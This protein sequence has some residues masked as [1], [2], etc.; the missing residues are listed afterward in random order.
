[1]DEGDRLIKKLVGLTDETM[2]SLD[3]ETNGTDPY[4][5]DILLIALKLDDEEL[6]LL[7]SDKNVPYI[8]DLISH[9]PKIKILGHN[10]KFDF[11]FI[12]NKFGILF[13]NLFDTFIA[14]SV[15]R[16][17]LDSAFASLDELVFKYTNRSIDKALRNEFLYLKP[18][19]YISDV[20]IEYA[21]NDV[22]YL[23]EIY[24]KQVS[25]L[26]D[27]KLTHVAEL[28]MKLLPVVVVMETLGIKVDVQRW[29]NVLPQIESKIP[30]LEESLKE[31][32]L[33]KLSANF[34]GKNL[35][36][37]AELLC[38]PVKSKKEQKLLETITDFHYAKDWLMENINLS[39][40]KQILTVMNLLGIS[41]PNTNEQ[42]LRDYMSFEFIQKLL[43]FRE[44]KKLLTTYGENILNKINPVTK[45]LHPEFNQ[46]GTAT[47]RFSSVNPNCQNI[48]AD[49]VFRSN[50]VAR[51]GFKLIIADYNQQEY[52]LAGALTGDKQIIAAYKAGHDIH[53]S[54]AAIAYN[55]PL[56]EVTKEQRFDGKRINFLT[57]Y[58]GSPQKL[59][60]VLNLSLERS[61]EII[62]SINNSYSTSIKFRD[63]YGEKA[64]EVGYSITAFGRKRFYEKPKIY[65]SLEEFNAIKKR[66][67]RQA[68]NALIQGTG[69]D[70][71]KLAM[72]ECF[73]NNPFGLDNF[74]M[75]LQVHDEIVFEVRDS[76]VDEAVKFIKETLERVEQKFLGEIPAV[77][78]I[79]VNDFWKK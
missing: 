54:T 64:F 45:C 56:S 52:R 63:L 55:V 59:H 74:R 44:L 23:S 32:I 33:D 21:L 18:G 40:H 61:K 70:I 20:L 22:R 50:F 34:D 12:F 3:I 79:N 66:I 46:N 76:I 9:N 38:I 37:I 30:Q 29:L 73:Y 60:K 75:L 26:K 6:C 24:H 2:L 31:Y 27:L 69:A 36:E 72:V 28:E 10:L 71:V 17:G 8:L 49:D 19:D 53:T 16:A 35:Y 62:D 78:E 5:S 43:E 39:S 13:Y 7:P 11:K 25:L 1:M 51:D 77:V 58:G 48:P 68:Y 47:G 14:E 57:L 4:T 42:T 41:V 15:L 67:K 65:S